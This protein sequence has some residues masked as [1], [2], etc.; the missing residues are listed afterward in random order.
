MTEQE[1]DVDVDTDS[2]D[3]GGDLKSPKKPYSKLAVELTGEDLKSPGV[4]K[5][6][7]AE[8]SRLEHHSLKYD[9]C[10]DELSS[11]KQKCA[12]LEEKQKTHALLEVLY[13]AGLGV[14]AVLIGL[15]PS[16][17]ESTFSP[18]VVL[19]LGVILILVA[20]AAKLRHK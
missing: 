2:D 18:L 20:I 3:I 17:K 1:Q 8:I 6:L 14:G 12:V 9:F 7:L 10:K 15:T 19:G 13:T 5:L 4:Q 11:A 16:V